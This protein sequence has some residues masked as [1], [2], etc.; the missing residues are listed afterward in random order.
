MSAR[1]VA[2]LGSEGCWILGR[3]GHRGHSC[4]HHVAGTGGPCPSP[5][6]LAIS[7][8]LSC[9]TVWVGGT[10]VDPLCSTPKGWGRRLFT[11]LSFSLGRELSWEF[12]LGAERCWP[13]N[14]HDTGKTKLPYPF[15]VV[16]LRLFCSAVWLKLLKW[17]SELSK[18]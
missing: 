9:A 15:H 7:R 12:P 2:V 8:C 5:F 11:L 14:W 4:A 17:T 10:K 16:I 3:A 6:F 13:G 18:S 1:A